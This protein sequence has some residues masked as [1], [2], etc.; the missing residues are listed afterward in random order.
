MDENS[1]SGTIDEM[2]RVFR[3][4]ADSSRRRLLDRL[5]VRN[6]QSLRELGTGLKMA[7]QSVSKHLAILEAANLVTTVRS[8]REKLHYLN[9]VPINDITERWISSYDRERVR[10]LSD[11]KRV[12]EGSR[13]DRPKSVYTIYINTT[14]EQLWQA[15][16]DP[17]FTRQWW[18]MSAQTDWKVGSPITWEQHGVTIDDPEQVVLEYEPNHRLAFTW[19]AFTPPLAQLHGYSEER[20]S[21][22][23]GEPRS[24][25]AFTLEP[26]GRMVKLTVVHDDFAPES[27][28]LVMVSK[29]WPQVLSSLK[30]L[31]ET[32]HPLDIDTD[33][34]RRDRSISP[35]ESDQE[36][37]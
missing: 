9:A 23:A 10:T 36:D 8:G 28:V 18:R 32:G 35:A 33:E 24:R 21:A 6:G 13:M 7:R 16:I 30:S 14:P 22:L 5:R 11:L 25:V 26:V 1:G 31:L 20:R 2:E 12:L 19:H 3:A 4:L 37:S 17:A 34:A 29:G 15:L 27:A